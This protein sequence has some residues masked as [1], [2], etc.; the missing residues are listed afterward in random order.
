LDSPKAHWFV[1]LIR[2]KHF[3]GR[4]S[5]LDELET[6]LFAE[7]YCQKVA[8]RGLGGIGKTQIALELAYRSRERCRDCSVFWI[9]ANNANSF[10]QACLE[11]A[12]LLQINGQQKEK[13][14]AKKL[15]KHW[16]SQESAGQWLL[17]L[18]NVDDVDI[19][20]ESTSNGTP[21]ITLLDYIPT[22]SKG[23]IVFTTR[24]RKG[25]VKLARSNVIEIPEMD[26]DTAAEVLSKAL[27]DPT[28]LHDPQTTTNLLTQLTCLPLAIVQAATYINK[29]G[30]SVLEY[31]SLFEDTKE[32]DI[33][34]VLSE[35]FED[36]GRYKE[37]NNP[38]ATTWLISFEQIQRHDPLAAQYLSFMSCIDSKHIPQSLLPLAQSKKQRLDAIGTLSAFS[39]IAKRS[40]DLS[41]DL[42]RLVHLATRNWLRHKSSLAEQVRKAVARLAEVFADMQPSE[43]RRLA[44]YIPHAQFVLTSEVLNGNTKEEITLLEAIGRWMSFCGRYYEAEKIFS[45]VFRWRKSNLGPEH[46]DTFNSGDRLAAASLET[47]NYEA[48]EKIS[49]QLFNMK[50]TVLGQEHSDTLASMNNVARAF[51]GQGRWKEAED[52]Q[53]EVLEKCKT[54][55]GPEHQRTV[56]S[57]NNLGMTFLDQGRLKEAEALQ[58]EAV[59]L[60]ELSPEHPERLNSMSNLACIFHKQRRWKKAEELLIQVMNTSKKVLGQEHP[61]TMLSMNNLAGTWRSKGCYP[62]AIKLMEECVELRRKVLGIDHPDTKHSF[63][64]LNEWRSECSEFV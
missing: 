27:I 5:Q 34:E 23:S 55:L 4:S 42:H 46:T 58:V 61:D 38:V 19:A 59:K 64:R 51:H 60:C 40:D 44:A 11:I 62:E 29:T 50:V 15:V 32:E 47:H 17:I 52:L 6:K 13:S 9:P 20:F 31:L 22:S 26:E 48:A 39:F 3:V 43:L 57:M 54:V 18:D 7:G 36:D 2:N 16:L 53:R 21:G 45:K 12:Q 1:P 28:I 56:I 41:F 24:D 14:D 63:K 49:Q 37:S 25:A 30:L 8:I 10:E 35:D 33:I